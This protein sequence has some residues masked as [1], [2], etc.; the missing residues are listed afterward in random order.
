MFSIEFPLSGIDVAAGRFLQTVEGKKHFAFYGTMGAG[1]TTF[2]KAA[3]TL[4]G[5]KN[6][7]TS[8]TFAIVNE[9]DAGRNGII[10]H[11]DFYRINRPEE[12]FDLGCEEYF[13]SD[14]YCFVEWPEKAGPALPDDICKLRI[15]ETENGL[16]KL[17]L[18]ETANTFPLLPISGAF[19]SHRG[20][21]TVC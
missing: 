11:F 21:F 10:Y 6:T 8:P 2:I 18:I 14:G 1:K 19:P 16:R 13:A 3:C 7:V 15:E 12:V 9:Y 20:M 4:L 17:S 5:V